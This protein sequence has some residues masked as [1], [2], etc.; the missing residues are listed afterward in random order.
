MAE[1]TGNTSSNY[2]NTSISKPPNIITYIRDDSN[3]NP[4]IESLTAGRIIMDPRSLMASEA[5]SLN[6]FRYDR[7]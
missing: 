6:L 3:P 7:T 1:E 5:G 4:I 2:I